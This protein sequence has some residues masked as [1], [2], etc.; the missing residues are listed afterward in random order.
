MRSAVDIDSHQSGMDPPGQQGILRE[1]RAEGRNLDR[2][3]R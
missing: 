1:A 3:E 2:P